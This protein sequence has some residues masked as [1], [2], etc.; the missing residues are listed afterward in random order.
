MGQRQV[1]VADFLAGPTGSGAGIALQICFKLR[2][3]GGDFIFHD[4][5]IIG[6][7]LLSG[8]Q[9]PGAEDNSPGR[10]TAGSIQ[11]PVFSAAGDAFAGPEG[12]V[13]RST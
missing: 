6:Y 8:R 5:P 3:E 1:E 12:I 9:F 4:Q 10:S 2:E 11:L 7:R 13:L